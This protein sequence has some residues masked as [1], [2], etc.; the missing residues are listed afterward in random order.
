MG[1]KGKI[2]KPKL[3]KSRKFSLSTAADTSVD[4]NRERPTF[5]L[6]FVDPNYCIT[7][8]ERD[9]K[10]AFADRIRLLSGMTWNQLIQAP[11]HGLGLENIARSA[12][13]GTIPGHLTEDVTFIALRFSGIKSMVGYRVQGMFHIVWFDCNL[14]LYDH[15]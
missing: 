11:R 1:D 12:I 10:A 7:K 8:C 3:D 14:D 9:D 4:Y 5:C 13:R 2:L 15:G 6:R